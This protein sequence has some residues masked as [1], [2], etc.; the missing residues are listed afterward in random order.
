ML[1]VL[2]G[3]GGALLIA[4]IVWC[5]VLL[6]KISPPWG[7]INLALWIVAIVGYVRLQD[8]YLGWLVWGVGLCA[9]AQAPLLS[10]HQ[11]AGPDNWPRRRW[12]T[13]LPVR[14]AMAQQ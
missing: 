7:A 3:A 9:T 14:I 13:D 8:T 4:S 5:G 12:P 2:A 10:F 6:F 11:P 1:T